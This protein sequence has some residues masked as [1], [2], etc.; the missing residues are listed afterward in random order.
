MALE[1][2][3]FSE[4]KR[5]KTPALRHHKTN[6]LLEL[7]EASDVPCAPTLTRTKMRQQPRIDASGIIIELD[8]P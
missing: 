2:P 6:G 7:W 3:N 1:R 8:H 4:D 5:F